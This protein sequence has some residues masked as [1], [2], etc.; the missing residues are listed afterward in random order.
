MLEIVTTVDNRAQDHRLR[1][2]F[3]TG[4]RTDSVFA[5]SQF[6][7]VE[8]EQRTYPVK[9]FTI[10]HPAAVAPM[11]RFVAAADGKR[12]LLVLTDGLPEYELRLDRPRSIAVTLLRCVGLLAGEDLITRPG[13]KAGWHN[14][15]PDAQ[16]AGVHTFRYG[17]MPLDG[18]WEG[19]LSAINQASEAFHLP[20]LAV[21]RKNADL[22]PLRGSF[23]SLRQPPDRLQRTERIARPE[24]TSWCGSTT[25]RGRPE[26]AVLRFAGA[27]RRPGA[28]GSTRRRG[29]ARGPGDTRGR[30]DHEPQRDRHTARE[31]DA[32]K[33]AQFEHDG[34]PLIGIRSA[35]SWINY[36][37]A[38]AVFYLQ[39][40]NIH[41]DPAWTITDLLEHEEFDLEELAAVDRFV[42]GNRL[43]KLF[44]VPK[45]ARMKAPTRAPAEDRGPRTELRPSC[46][47]GERACAPRA[48]PL[49]EGGI[50][51]DRARRADPCS[52]GR[53]EGGP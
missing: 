3:P 43:E 7:V 8:R 33:V 41:T 39:V 5:D 14:E 4:A 38:A 13:G 25:L 48:D 31:D 23:C 47:G 34:N 15:T 12:G 32:M 18:P 21:R 26:A 28:R 30:R 35:A 2:L 20:L 44:R 46:E 50:V 37:K 27:L 29:S 17:L 51:G 1:V 53:R 24:A 49:L 22:P 40:H 9:Q 6:C 19:N 11:Q 45:E 52:D 10:E 42:R 16:C 36:T